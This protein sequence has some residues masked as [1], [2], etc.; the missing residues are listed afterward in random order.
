MQ[1]QTNETLNE[2]F[3][4]SKFDG[5]DHWKLTI[6]RSISSRATHKA[7]L[8]SRLERYMA[9]YREK[10]SDSAVLLLSSGKEFWMTSTTADALTPTI[11]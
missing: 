2:T 5:W 11:K 3:Q 1:H 6:P 7:N 8:A 10:E 9:M 4:I